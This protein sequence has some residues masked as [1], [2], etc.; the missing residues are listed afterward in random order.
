M[1]R[2]IAW[3]VLLLFFHTPAI[4]AQTKSNI[5][6]EETFE[7]TN[8]FPLSGTAINKTKAVENFCTNLCLTEPPLP[9]GI[10]CSWPLSTVTSPVYQGNKA[11]RF[12]V[13]KDQPLEGGAC[14]VRSEVVIIAGNDTRFNNTS[15]RWYSYDVYFPSVGMEAE[16]TRDFVNQW[17]EDGGLDCQVSTKNG[18]LNFEVIDA[19]GSTTTKFFDLF[20]VPNSASGANITTAGTAFTLIPYNV[21]N[22]FVFHFK[23]DET[24][25]GLIEIWRNGVKIQ[26]I[27]GANMHTSI[28]PKWKMG[29]YR[30]SAASSNQYSRVLYFDNVRVGNSTATLADMS[31]GS[32]VAPFA[33]AGQ[34]ILLILPTDTV[35][36]TG[37]GIANGGILSYQW[38]EIAGPSSV[39]IGTPSLSST[40]LSIAGQGA[41]SFEFRVTDN[42]G[43]VGKDTVNVVVVAGVLPVK[44][45]SFTGKLLNGNVYLQWEPSNESNVMG[46]D[47]E[48]MSGTTWNSIASLQPYI[49][50]FLSSRYHVTD[51]SLSL[52][53]NFYRLKM[54][55]V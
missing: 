9:P 52:G 20:G 38:T 22:S 1:P 45:T 13:R 49:D 12:E 10:D 36:L 24:G 42:N 34:D 11:V 27:S 15:D 3:F 21:W 18:R 23:H 30:P 7:G 19:I 32:N 46:Y 51:F 5:I 43:A 16:S 17:Y 31:S 4:P 2:L 54:V 48:K 50:H 28:L 29:V 35:S 41:F 25:A 8:Y 14:R 6:Y 55:N 33:N 47:V 44:L 26:T 40:K 37:T 39:S 53:A